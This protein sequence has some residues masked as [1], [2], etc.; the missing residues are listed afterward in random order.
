[1]KN[2]SL[3]IKEMMEIDPEFKK[4]MES[5]AKFEVYTILNQPMPLYEIVEAMEKTEKRRKKNEQI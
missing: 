5:C 1:M 4:Y 2:K 3:T